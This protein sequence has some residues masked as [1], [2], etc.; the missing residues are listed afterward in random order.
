MLAPSWFGFALAL[1]V[2]AAE[3]KRLILWAFRPALAGLPVLL[4]G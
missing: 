3:E 4:G 1:P 2:F